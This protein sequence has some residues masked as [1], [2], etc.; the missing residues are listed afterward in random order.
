LPD[1]DA[2]REIFNIHL[3]KRSISALG[4]DFIDLVHA[5]DGF[6]GVEIEQAIV[7]AIYTAAAT[8]DTL[9][10]AHILN[11][12]NHNSPLSVVMAE[13]VAEL[14]HWAEERTVLAN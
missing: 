10:D 12:I 4:F 5:S 2:W 9:A 13:K 6:S 14:R 7:A 11:E 1:A 3:N 8:Q